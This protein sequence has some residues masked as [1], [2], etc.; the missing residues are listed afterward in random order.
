MSID[1]LR[2]KLASASFDE[3]RI[4]AISHEQLR[5]ALAKFVLMEKVQPPLAAAAHMPAL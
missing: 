1:R 3:Q 2:V 4:P 5:G